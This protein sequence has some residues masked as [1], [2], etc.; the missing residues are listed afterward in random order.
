MYRD[1]YLKFF[2]YQCMLREASLKN[3]FF[4][5]N[6]TQ[7]CGRLRLHFETR[8]EKNHLPDEAQRPDVLGETLQRK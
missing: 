2:K 4:I 5:N 1:L 6:V 8:I 7:S 3:I